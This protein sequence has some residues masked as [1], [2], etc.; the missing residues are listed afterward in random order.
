MFNVFE[1]NLTSSAQL[2]WFYLVSC[3]KS[4]QANPSLRIIAQKCKLS[5]PVVIKAL[6]ALESE[7]FIVRTVR[8]KPDGSFDNNVYTLVALQREQKRGGKAA[9]A[10]LSATAVRPTTT[11]RVVVN[12]A[13]TYGRRGG[14]KLAE[15]EVARQVAAVLS[16]TAAGG[17][18]NQ[19][20]NNNKNINIYVVVVNNTSENLPA[21]TDSVNKAE[22][23]VS[24]QEKVSNSEDK[25]AVEAVVNRIKEV[26]GVEV[27]TGYASKI[28]KKYGVDRVYYAIAEME[29]QIS[30]GVVI[31]YTCSWL[32][33]A[34][35][36]G[37][38]PD[39][40]A[41]VVHLPNRAT[42]ARPAAAARPGRITD[43]KKKDF[44]RSLYAL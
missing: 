42:A 10:V 12:G 7:G 40:P 8:R 24:G 14:G 4:Y 1:S 9:A 13:T 19:V 5:K 36:E 22:K 3:A 16:A 26:S 31:R 27:S 28:V 32:W 17:V 29:R 39:Q 44:I 33:R 43:E 38:K 41:R 2:V 20:D 21:T 11:A 37:Y 6:R 23:G 35:E 18:V 30:R 34:L 15:E 25:A